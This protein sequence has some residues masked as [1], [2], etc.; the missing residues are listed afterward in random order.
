MASE[1]RQNYTR[2]ESDMP[3]NG[4]RGRGHPRCTQNVAAPD[5][6]GRHVGVR[7]ANRARHNLRHL[8]ERLTDARMR[9]GI[10]RNRIGYQLLEHLHHL[11]D[12]FIVSRLLIAHGLRLMA[13]RRSG[14]LAT[15]PHFFHIKLE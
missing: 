7:Q 13:T 9:S 2:V 11:P 12:V 1:S 6:G 8:H 5:E 3:A 15:R 4:Y 10:S 14:V